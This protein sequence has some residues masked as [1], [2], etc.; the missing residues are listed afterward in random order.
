MILQ[1]LLSFIGLAV[2]GKIPAVNAKI[3]EFGELTDKTAADNTAIIQL[4]SVTTILNDVSGFL[5]V[6]KRGSVESTENTSSVLVTNKNPYKGCD[7]WTNLKA[8]FVAIQSILSYI[9]ALT[10]LNPIILNYVKNV[11]DPFVKTQITQ[12]ENKIRYFLSL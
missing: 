10:Y 12:I 4:E 5:T 7:K 6:R 2:D 1:I 8:K 9:K 3:T 11:L